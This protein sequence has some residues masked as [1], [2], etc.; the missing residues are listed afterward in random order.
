MASSDADKLERGALLAADQDGEL[1]ITSSV[2]DAGVHRFNDRLLE[3]VPPPAATAKASKSVQ[4]AEQSEPEP[5]PE[6]EPEAEPEPEP[7][8]ER[9]DAVQR[10]ALSR[11]TTLTVDEYEGEE[12]RASP[13][14]KFSP[15]FLV[16]CSQSFHQYACINCA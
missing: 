5:E 11:G 8:P 12:E 1:G 9:E 2:T 14:R 7:E 6:P 15:A 16:G 3:A 10:D 4:F 13:S